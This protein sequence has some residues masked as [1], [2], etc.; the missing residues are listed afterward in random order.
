MSAQGRFEGVAV[1]V[2]GGASGIGRAIVGRAAQEGARIAILDRNAEAARSLADVLVRDGQDAVA[3]VADIADD[4]AVALAVGEAARALGPIGILVN[5]AGATRVQT[6]ADMDPAAWRSEIEINLS[7]AYYVTR[8]VI[9][10]MLELGRGAIVNVATVNALTTL[11]EPAYSAAKAGLLQL[12]RQIAVEYGPQGIRA[13]AVVPGSIRT[14]IW[15]HRLKDRP[16]LF[17]VLRRWYPVGRIG[18]PEDVAA[19]AL[20][21]AS[22]EAG[23]ING[24]SLVVDGGL[25]AG[26]PQMTQ[27]ILTAG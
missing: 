10:S 19:A 1:L 24:A 17:D 6:F 3:V 22:S 7:G 13:N 16:G 5:N 2:T 11:S 12:T 23:F 14:P 15:D 21:L 25:T 20:F 26:V 27:D 4:S 9:P 8:A 18:E